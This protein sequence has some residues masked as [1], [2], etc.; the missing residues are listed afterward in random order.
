MTSKWWYSPSG[1]IFDV[2]E[3]FIHKR[4]IGDNREMLQDDY[5]IEMN[6]LGDMTKQLV[7][8]GWARIVGNTYGVNADVLE[9]RIGDLKNFLIQKFPQLWREGSD[10]VVIINNTEP[11]ATE[12]QE[13]SSLV[14]AYLAGKRSMQ[15]PSSRM[16]PNL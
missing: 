10:I 12:V 1:E 2:P 16:V 9:S 4:W 13:H 14:K 8:L 11:S 6:I 15:R 5:G 7:E 3:P